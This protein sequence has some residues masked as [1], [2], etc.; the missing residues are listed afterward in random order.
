MTQLRQDMANALNARNFGQ[1]AA[2]ESS[3]AAFEN[4]QRANR[5]REVQIGQYV[6][7]ICTADYFDQ[8]FG[9]KWVKAIVRKYAAK[10]PSVDSLARQTGAD[11]SSDVQR[12]FGA[13]TLDKA[14][15][16]GRRLS[17]TVI[18]NHQ[19]AR[20]GKTLSEMGA[21]VASVHGLRN[22]VS[23]L[24]RAQRKFGQH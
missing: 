6:Q 14:L 11:F 24:K 1:I 16:Y 5:T 20:D 21:E 8:T 12:L 17:E 3:I 10:V 13:A 19:E 15:D 4:A 7:S 23:V 22:D 2:F 9:Q 18:D